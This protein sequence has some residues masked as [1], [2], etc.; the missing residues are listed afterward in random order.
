M[1]S[2]I[3]INSNSR[4]IRVAL[5]ENHQLVEIFVEHKA[6]KGIVGNVYKGVVTK[7][8]PGMQ[9]AFVDIGL[10]KAG[11][12]YVG[13]IDAGDLLDLDGED[14][15]RIDINEHKDGNEESETVQPT[16]S[17]DHIPIQ[18]LLR[19]GQEI[20]VQVAKNPLG[21]K[22]ARI[23][24]YITLAGR[25]IVYMPTVDQVCVSRR[26]EDEAEKE[27]LKSILGEIGRN[28][29]GYIIRTAGQG[30]QKEDFELDIQF[31]HK[32]G[33]NLTG[34]SE[35]EPAPRLLYEDL[36]L[37]FRSIRDLFNEDV[38][39]LVIDSKSDYEKCIEFCSNYL[40]ELAD[41]IELYKEPV[42]IFD[43]FGIEIEMNRALG[44]KIWLKSGGFIAIDQTEAL[45]A[46]DVNTGK[47]VGHSDPEET[48]L[49]TNLEA[50]KEI[51]YQLRL[52]NIGGIII[53]DF[54]D[55]SREESKEIVWSALQQELRFD[56]SR[57][58]ILKISELGLVE[59]TRK[60]VRGSLS[61]TLCDPCP[62]C[63]GK[64]H[65]KSPA[66]V[67]Y[68]IIRALQRMVGN[69]L[70]PQNITIEVPPPVYDLLFEEETSYFDELEKFYGIEVHI[71]VNPKLHQ[72]K[73]N[74]LT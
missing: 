18:D 20:M 6:K 26:I 24:S 48:I 16:R 57:T 66:T 53:V 37:I 67:C 38:Q 28:G 59:M 14:S 64:G 30:R 51:V 40:P 13:D 65:I 42:P 12:L 9:V 34:R 45:V 68:E 50:V 17:M 1:A 63:E 11:F 60:R 52:R 3:I 25:H 7:I 19:E 8:L 36:N 54:I 41:K 32:L 56:R 35:S 69:H 27:R 31:L 71:K 22:G 33:D 2:E 23:T 4:E 15:D 55:M 21:T 10:E 43:Y 46:I 47:F 39:R 5:V 44:R 29:E 58:N 70:T 74:I 61:Q 49:K 73:Y 62:Y 72:E